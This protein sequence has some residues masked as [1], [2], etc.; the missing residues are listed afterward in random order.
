MVTELLDD[1]DILLSRA[2]DDVQ[3]VY[4]RVAKKYERFRALWVQL[5]GGPSNH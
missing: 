4:E 2:P 5:A 1:L 3:D